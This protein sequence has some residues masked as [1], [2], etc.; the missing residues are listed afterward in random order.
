MWRV[1]QTAIS[2]LIDPT[3]SNGIGGF[4]LTQVLARINEQSLQLFDFEST[5]YE[6][7]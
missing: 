7:H 5:V 1:W 2:G 6:S 4:D 3:R